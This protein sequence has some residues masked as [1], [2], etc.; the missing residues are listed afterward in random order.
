MVDRVRVLAGTNDIFDGTGDFYDVEKIIVH[1][2]FE[3]TSFH[4]DISLVRTKN[5]IV[6]RKTESNYRVNSVCLPPYT[7]QKVPYPPPTAVVSGWGSTKADAQDT[8][9]KLL[10]VTVSLIDHDECMKVYADA[11]KL[12]MSRKTVCYGKDN[13]DSCQGD[14]GGPLVKHVAGQTTTIGIVSFGAGCGTFPG[15]YTEVSQYR[16]WINDN[17]Y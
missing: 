15:V 6:F 17:I 11:H 8:P 2:N 3:D 7:S 1:D 16:D 9:E 12:N 10:K 13:K 14:S 5:P 4:N